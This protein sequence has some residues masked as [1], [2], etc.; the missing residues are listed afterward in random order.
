MLPPL[1][2]AG[3][4]GAMATLVA[5]SLAAITSNPFS[6]LDQMLVVTLSLA[7]A[8]GLADRAAARRAAIL[9]A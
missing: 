2:R 5:F 1:E 8:H 7:L 3:A 6:I 4:F 9:G